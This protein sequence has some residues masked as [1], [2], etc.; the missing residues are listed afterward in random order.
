M[1]FLCSVYTPRALELSTALTRFPKPQI[2]PPLNY[3]QFFCQIRPSKKIRFHHRNPNWVI[4]SVAEDREVVPVKD[5]GS[6]ELND[7]PTTSSSDSSKLEA[8]GGG[9]SDRLTTRVINAIIVLGFGSFAVTKLLTID[10][11]Y[12]QVSILNTKWILILCFKYGLSLL[13]SVKIVIS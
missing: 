13:A 2:S 1:A 8:H 5:D 10:H 12:W 9:D 6:D 11:D 3:S 7:L 4:G